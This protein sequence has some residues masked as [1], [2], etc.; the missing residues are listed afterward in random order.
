MF[1][2]VW[3]SRGM[4]GI[5]KDTQRF[6]IPLVQSQRL[7]EGGNNICCAPTS[8]HSPKKFKLTRVWTESRWEIEEYRLFTSESKDEQLIDRYKR[9]MVRQFHLNRSI[10]L[11]TRKHIMDT[12][13]AHISI[14]N[15]GGTLINPH[16]LHLGLGCADGGYQSLVRPSTAS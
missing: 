16:R 12:Q 3:L 14:Q 5:P 15:S 8:C 11:S 10:N 1:E 7:A 13:H 4:R 2:G 9:I 6:V